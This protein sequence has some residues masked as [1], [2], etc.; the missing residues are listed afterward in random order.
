MEPK[1]RRE[2]IEIAIIVAVIFFTIWQISQHA[3]APQ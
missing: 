3:G 1:R 2:L